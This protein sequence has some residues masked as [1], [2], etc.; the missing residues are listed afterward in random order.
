MKSDSIDS[1]SKE[2][3]QSNPQKLYWQANLRLLFKLLA[4]WFFV[5]FGCGIILA[6]WLDQFSISGFKLGFWFSQQGAIYVFV[7]LIFV[8]SKQMK[9]LDR[10]FGLEDRDDAGQTHENPKS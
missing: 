2:H 9:V 4:V 10:Q 5:S 3:C 6:D 7:L 1:D 8:Y